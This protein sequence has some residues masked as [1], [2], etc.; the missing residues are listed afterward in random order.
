MA[1]RSTKSG[2]VTG[3]LPRRRIISGCLL[4]LTLSLAHAL[5]AED[6]ITLAVDDSRRAALPG[7]VTPHIQSGTDLGP[8]DPSMAL[9]Y[10]TLVL[11]PSSSQQADLDQLLAQQQDPSSPNY[12]RWLTPEQYADCFGVSQS[13][14]DKIVSWLSQHGLT[15]KSVARSRNAIAFGGAASQ[16]GSA[17]GVRIHS[18]NVGG[19]QHYANSTD[20][21]IPV[22]FQG[23]VLTIRGLH[24]FRLKPRLRPSA[25]PRDNLQGAEQLA[26]DDIAT[27]YNITPLYDAGIDGAGQKLA[28][29]GQTDIIPADI[30][31]Y[32][33]YFNL[34]VN[35]PTVILVD[36]QDPGIQA[37]SGDLGESDLDL[38][39]AGAVARNAT[40]Y[41]VTS[42]NVEDS[43]SYAVTDNVAPIVSTSYGDC[44][45]D[46]GSAGAQAL[47]QL[48]MQANAQGQTVFAASGDAGAL[49]CYGLGDGTAIDN[50]LSVDMPAS[51]PQV[52]GVGGTQFNEGSGTYWSSTNTSNQASAL[53][54]IPEIPWN[55]G[56]N[57]QPPAGPEATGGGESV[58]FT[59][60]SWQTGS[61]VP[62]DGARDVPDVSISAS[63]DHDGYLMVSQGSLQIIG[64]TSVGGPQ[65]AGIAALLSHYLVKN[66]FQSSQSLGNINPT[67]YQL[68]SVAGVFHDITTGSNMVPPCQGCTASG[69]S[70][71]PGYDRVTGLGTPNVYNLV[72][73]WHGGSVTSKGSVTMALAA[74]AASVTFSE[75]TVL[76]ATVTSASGAEPTGT[77]TFSTGSYALG[78]AALNA[79]GVATLTLSGVQ[80]PVG[81][82]SI[83]AQYNGDTNYFG[84]A[85]TASVT[86]TSPT[87]G[88]PSVGGLSNAAS[89]T[90]AFAPGGIVSVFGTQ[91]A[92]ATGVADTVPL[93]T[94]LAGTWATI[95]GIAAPLYFVS[96]KQMNIQIPYEVPVN[97]TATLRIE[98]GASVFFP[99]NVSATAPA[100]FTTNQQGTGQGEILD[101]ASYLLVDASHPATPG[102]T[103]IQIYC[104]GLG[105]VTNQ[106]ADGAAAL[107]SPLSE[108]ST[109]P[110]VTVGGISET[111]TFSGLAPGFVGLYQVNALVPSG[112]TAGPAVQVTISIGG[113]ASN[114]V[115]IAVA[116]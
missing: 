75:T 104:M 52:T 116:Q 115:T 105:A 87:T 48:G 77:V 21:T 69:Y 74:S 67:L 86:E 106:P 98:N 41:F 10:V 26:P 18:Y 56:F 33:S 65:F 96:D 4:V 38:E 53:F 7:S 28:I 90:Q 35:N 111:A 71:G 59:K 100:I 2:S 34:P 47:E 85:A 108:T 81:G 64:G 42:T 89:Y 32:R 8:V 23:V 82:N 40:I 50:A 102:S 99:F 112:V 39:F 3:P 36:N 51:L 22:A 84:A 103:Y 73:A 92:P 80:L 97:S 58:F 14:I 57:P 95:N 110:Q 94:I 83:T 44:E 12:H 113:V 20:P 93:P 31:Q 37:N 76:T 9:P 49:D 27:I 25:H 43:L 91:L 11:K 63:P 72:T 78:T 88:P 61:G 109:L 15:L 60:P 30:Q 46:T 54:Y 55:E 13:D 107:S 19:E 29:V 101:N 1:P 6:R 68:A 62:N 17:F 79:N 70:A 5:G 45:L 16:I 66:G 114:T 24:D